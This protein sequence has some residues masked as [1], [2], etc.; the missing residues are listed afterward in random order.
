MSVCLEWFLHHLSRARACSS[1]SAHR[2][3][4]SVHACLGC[5][6][7]AEWK[8]AV[9]SAI[10][11][12]TLYVE[13]L[14]EGD[15]LEDKELAE[16]SVFT[17]N[18][19][20]TYMRRELGMPSPS[21]AHEEDSEGDFA[22]FKQAFSKT[23]HGL[24]A[25][26]DAE[27]LVA[28]RVHE[29]L[30]SRKTVASLEEEEKAEAD[31]EQGSGG[32]LIRFMSCMITLSERS[33][34][35]FNVAF[36]DD[37]AHD[38]NACMRL[39]PPW[40][41]EGSYEY[42]DVA[43][44][45]LD[46][47]SAVIPPGIELHVFCGCRDCRHRLVH[48]DYTTSDGTANQPTAAPRQSCNRRNANP[49]CPRPTPGWGGAPL[50]PTWS[51]LCAGGAQ[52]PE[53]ADEEGGEQTEPE[54]PHH[55]VTAIS[56]D[57]S[58]WITTA[59]KELHNVPDAMTA[60]TTK[61]APVIVAQGGT[62]DV[63]LYA[64][65]DL[66]CR[67]RVSDAS[68]VTINGAAELS[69]CVAAKQ[70]YRLSLEYACS[71][72]PQGESGIVALEVSAFTD[73][74]GSSSNTDASVLIRLLLS[75]CA[76]EMVNPLSSHFMRVIQTYQAKRGD[77][78]ELPRYGS[79]RLDA[80]PTL[81][82]STEQFMND[83]GTGKGRELF[84][85]GSIE[86]I[87][88]SPSISECVECKSKQVAAKCSLQRCKR[89]CGRLLIEGC[90]YHSKPSGNGN[91]RK[92]KGKRASARRP[93]VAAI[94]PT[95]GRQ[96]GRGI[97]R[98]ERAACTSAAPA[99]ATSKRHK[100]GTLL[101]RNVTDDT[102]LDSLEVAYLTQA[103][104]ALL[105]RAGWKTVAILAADADSTKAIKQKRETFMTQGTH[106]GQMPGAPAIQLLAM[107]LRQAC[108]GA[109]VAASVEVCDRE[110]EQGT[111][112]EQ[113]VAGEGGS[114]SDGGEESEEE[115]EIECIIDER[116]TGDGQIEYRVRWLGYTPDDDTWEC[117]EDLA[118]CEALSVWENSPHLSR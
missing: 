36:A 79:L 66:S 101:S 83:G 3:S 55:R 85:F 118:D 26:L 64:A 99:A 94:A 16:L 10:G 73:G 40:A 4:S 75:A 117:A 81:V 74:A 27:T 108:G 92:R 33:V 29:K 76:R 18:N 42:L 30:H 19:T 11:A 104:L 95:T 17:V 84:V 98:K 34:Q 68:M 31:A 87:V 103:K 15:D 78:A 62:T 1:R 110:D 7:D 89:C 116:Q 48:T 45:P 102:P 13:L 20:L 82:Q 8:V 96:N 72:R 88:G 86:D 58:C 105:V 44:C 5:R 54:R 25:I 69:V 49:C 100:A 28:R 113:G 24:H 106:E 56:A 60:G 111:E 77:E 57:R 23:N 38:E 12:T 90:A 46:S 50:T 109:L 114:E 67:V 37:C 97:K 112:H 51:L 91:R 22:A 47:S 35:R 9:Y 2:L 39:G 32:H 115:Y 6:S 93:A 107:Q 52:P 21:S 71:R 53:C 70:C 63:F 80:S 61:D 41:S 14:T 59:I 65:K 43:T